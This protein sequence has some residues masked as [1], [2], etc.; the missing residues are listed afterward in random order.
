MKEELRTPR[1]LTWLG[2]LVVAAFL[3]MSVQLSGPGTVSA[4]LPD[5]GDDDCNVQ[6]TKTNDTG[7]EVNED[8]SFS[9]TLEIEWD[10]DCDGE[11]IDVTDNLPSD[12]DV[13]DVD[14][15]NLGCESVED[16]IECDVD[17]N[18]SGRD[19]IEIE[20]EPTDC[21]DLTNSAS[22]NS[23][24]DEDS[25]EDTVEVLCDEDED[26]DEDDCPFD[27]DELDELDEDEEDEL[28]E[29][30]REA[31]DIDDEDEDD[32]DEDD[33]RITI[34]RRV[35]VISPPVVI[36]Q[37]QVVAAAPAPAPAPVVAP[38]PAPQVQLPRAGEGPAQSSNDLLPVG[39]G[40]VV[41]AFAGLAYWRLSR[42][43]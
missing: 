12:V 15:S 18:A 30:I 42:A 24:D 2:M 40:F 29:D 23:P 43:R 26:F 33:E 39:A 4:Q 10:D 20:V 35:P 21:G 17:P 28:D 37:P 6:I 5:D 7:G 3:A 11:D 32:E 14:E 27:D 31:C 22:V 8:E 34:V 16:P 41:V 25:D 1:M 38:A 13:L 9:W 36:P 19:E